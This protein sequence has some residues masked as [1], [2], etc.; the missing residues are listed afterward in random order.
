MFVLLL[1]IKSQLGWFGEVVFDQEVHLMLAV[2]NQVSNVLRCLLTFRWIQHRT[3]HCPKVG[4]RSQYVG[5]DQVLVLLDQIALLDQVQFLA[6]VQLFDV[7][8]QQVYNLFL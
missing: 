8:K 5:D 2:L 3:F 4:Q 6:L 1:R 7:A